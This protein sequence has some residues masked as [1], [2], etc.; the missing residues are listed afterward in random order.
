V[1]PTAVQRIDTNPPTD[2]ADRSTDLPDILVIAVGPPLPATELPFLARRDP[3][4]RRTTSPRRYGTHVRLRPQP[5]LHRAGACVHAAVAYLEAVTF[6]KVP[7]APPDRASAPYSVPIMS[8]THP[9]VTTVRRPQPAPLPSATP[10]RVLLSRHVAR[11]TLIRS[12]RRS[13]S[14]PGR[15]HRRRTD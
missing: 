2:V 15:L 12:Q 10:D 7:A 4:A 5:P 6:R 3:T 9:R 14:A 8:T 11:F 1:P 13:K